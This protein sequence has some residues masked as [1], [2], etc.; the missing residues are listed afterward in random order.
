MPFLIWGPF[1]GTD[2]RAN[3]NLRSGEELAA[4]FQR[5]PNRRVLPD[6]FEVIS[7]PIAFST[8]RVSMDKKYSKRA[9]VMSLI[10]L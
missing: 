10:I 7:E 2:L 4:G 5:I 1:S 8:I 3:R 6:Y 9:K